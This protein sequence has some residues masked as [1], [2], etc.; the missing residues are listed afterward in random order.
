MP[1]K[2]LRRW[3]AAIFVSTW[4]AYAGFYLTRR[5]YAVAQP[6]ILREFGWTETDVGVVI[7]LYLTAYAIGQFV[8]GWL[9]DRFGPRRMLAFGFGATILLS[10]GLGF[11][12]SVLGF[13]LLYGLNGFAQSAGWPN[14]TKAMTMWFPAANRGRVMG[15]WGT[16]YSFGDA[17]ATALAAWMLGTWGWRSV[18]WGPAIAGLGVAVL[19]VLILRDRPED[20]GLPPVQV[21]EPVAESEPLLESLKPLLDTR[22]LRLGAA[23]FC[24]K[25]VRYTFVFWIGL[26]L[27]GQLEFTD[28]QAGYLQVP[29]PLAGLLGSVAAGFA[30]DLLFDARRA[31]VAV[32]MLILLGGALGLLLALPTD[33]STEPILFGLGL[34]T[35]AFGGTLALCG[36]MLYGPDMLV[37]G[38]AAM[39]FGSTKAASRVA[40]FVNGVGSIGAALSGVVI[41]VVSGHGWTAVFAL[42]VVLVLACTVVTATL[43]NARDESAVEA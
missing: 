16:N 39:D 11:Q 29:F 36:F 32:I 35:L 40:G 5:N 19:V 15:I 7:T 43:W 14:V 1:D 37:S 9:G 24:L 3:Q 23:Y 38:T 18:F 12:G 2:R 30:S 6:A 10:V 8:H 13:G 26:Y 25:F 20:V 21:S 4:A 33:L 42:L 22:V 27:V 17:F 31:P 34:R 28:E 41:G